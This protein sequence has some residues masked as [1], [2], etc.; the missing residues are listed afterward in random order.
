MNLQSEDIIEY[1]LTFL[2]VVIVLHLCRQVLLSSG[3]T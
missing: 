1:I 2:G 3:D